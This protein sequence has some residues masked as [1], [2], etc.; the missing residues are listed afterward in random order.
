MWHPVYTL[1][2]YVQ[3]EWNMTELLNLTYGVRLTGH[4]EFGLHV[5]PKVSA[6]CKLEHWI[7]RLG[8]S[9]RFKTPTLKELYDNYIT[10]IGGGRLKHYY[11][12]CDLKPQESHYVSV[13]IEYNIL[14]LQVIR[15]WLCSLYM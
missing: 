4:K 10:I 9:M 8:Y 14:K 3:D 13:G 6:M 12:N 15:R 5:T 1:A 7:F 11:G 2:A